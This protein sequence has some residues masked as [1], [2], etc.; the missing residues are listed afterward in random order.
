MT[1]L[2]A[3]ESDPLLARLRQPWFG[4][5]FRMLTE[6]VTDPATL[7]A[8][9]REGGGFDDGPCQLA[10]R[11]GHEQ[12]LAR[13]RTQYESLFYDPVYRPLTLQ[14]QLVESGG[15]LCRDADAQP[16]SADQAA[17]PD[18]L[19]V[20]GDIGPLQSLVDPL[21]KQVKVSHET[22]HVP[23]GWLE[24]NGQVSVALTDGRMACE[25]QAAEHGTPLVL[26][27]LA[28][29]YS[30]TPR[31]ALARA[32]QTGDEQLALAVGLF[33]SLGK[34]VTVI[35]D[36]PGMVV[37]RSVAM[38]INQAAELI[39]QQIADRQTVDDAVRTG[40]G[41]TLGPTDWL[42]KLGVEQVIIVLEHLAAAYGPERYW[43]S[44]QLKR[45]R[46]TDSEHGN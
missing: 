29:D 10:D 46:Y 39:G 3:D 41:S 6:V 30:T 36:S 35:A 21:S 11:I 8:L 31:I 25:R 22:T 13:H 34:Q 4:E 18:K 24:L 12:L 2:S 27:D 38:L 19:V 40:L 9:L 5:A 14:R 33:Q 20:Y 32:E 1:T 16:V 23:A 7:D 15:Q 17:P 37:M 45:W 42:Q 26:V 43:P 28:A 44:L